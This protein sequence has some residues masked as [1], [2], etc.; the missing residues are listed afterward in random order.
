MSAN[1][2]SN[3]YTRPRHYHPQQFSRAQG[4]NVFLEKI[5][6]IALQRGYDRHSIGSA[7]PHPYFSADFCIGTPPQSTLP[8]DI[9]HELRAQYDLHSHC[10]F[11]IR[12]VVLREVGVCISMSERKL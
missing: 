3:E 1:V 9:Q 6:Q 12:P 7:S 2:S 4:T 8:I 5:Y 10:P 11:Y